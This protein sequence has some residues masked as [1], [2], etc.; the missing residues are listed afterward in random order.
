[1][2]FYSMT[3]YAVAEFSESKAQYRLHLKSVNHRFLEFRYKAPRDWAP[4]E[5]AA[6]E[7]VTQKLKRGSVELIVEDLSKKEIKSSQNQ[8]IDFF[9]SSL[10]KALKHSDHQFSFSLPS[11]IR[12]LILSRF[13]D[14]WWTE[15]E[16]E[17]SKMTAEKISQMLSQLCEQM[18][19]KRKTEGQKIQETLLKHLEHL[20]RS[21]QE[22]MKSR[23]E[24]RR[25]WETQYQERITKLAEELKIAPPPEEKLMQEF[26]VAAERRDIQEEIDRIQ[27]HVDALRS[28]LTSVHD[29]H[30]GKRVDFLTQELHREWTTLGNKIR[31]AKHSKL[32]IDAKLELEKIKE[33]TMNLA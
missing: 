26:L 33:Q 2:P 19:E 15:E 22:I 10:H 11:P 32:I 12:A 5:I 25:D 6:K 14:L 9:F 27:M 21:H 16:Q 4:Y 29:D 13:P 8:R 18:L 3:G 24:L 23:E 31:N 30:L 1:M 17:S 28:L 7:V 20:T